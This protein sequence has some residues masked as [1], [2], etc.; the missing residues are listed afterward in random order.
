[1]QEVSGFTID[2]QTTRISI[3]AKLVDEIH[4]FLDKRPERRRV[5]SARQVWSILGKLRHVAAAVKLRR[6]AAA[7]RPGTYFV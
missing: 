4:I 3:P 6:I 2:T 5:A 1:M 7:V